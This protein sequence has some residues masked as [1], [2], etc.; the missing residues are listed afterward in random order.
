MRHIFK[1]D[2]YCGSDVSVLKDVWLLFLHD[3]TNSHTRSWPNRWPS[4]PLTTQSSQNRQSLITVRLFCQSK[5]KYNSNIMIHFLGRHCSH[6][7]SHALATNTTLRP[8]CCRDLF[9]IDGA[10]VLV[11]P[12]QSTKLF[13]INN[14]G[15]EQI[16]RLWCFDT[17]SQALCP[18][19]LWSE[20]IFCP[21]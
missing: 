12:N 4:I 8:P 16:C 19:L 7:V 9:P 6:N 1:I 11:C 13:V 15:R 3:T 5:W 21:C 14:Y 20:G 2:V 17:C 18:V 10:L